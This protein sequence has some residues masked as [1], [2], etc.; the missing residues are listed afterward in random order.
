MLLLGC[1]YVLHNHIESGRPHMSC[2]P[3]ET[4]APGQDGR[5]AKC[6]RIHSKQ[7]LTYEEEAHRPG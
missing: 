7:W 5:A 1:K 6:A 2:D 3:V 4:N